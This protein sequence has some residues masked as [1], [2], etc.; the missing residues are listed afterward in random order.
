MVAI[1]VGLLSWGILIGYC[2]LL[3]MLA[4]GPMVAEQKEHR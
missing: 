4:V 3:L 2:A 1:L